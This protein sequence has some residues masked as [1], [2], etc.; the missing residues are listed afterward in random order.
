MAI[1]PLTAVQ[2]KAFHKQILSIG[3]KNISA[4]PQQSPD[5]YHGFSQLLIHLGMEPETGDKKPARKKTAA[6]KKATVKKKATVRRAPRSA[7]ATS[8]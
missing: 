7:R 4:D 1:K 6:R 8:K 3:M 5:V 2:L